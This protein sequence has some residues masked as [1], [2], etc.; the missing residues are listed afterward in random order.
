MPVE[1]IGSE[2]VRILIN[3]IKQKQLKMKPLKKE[4]I[5]LPCSL[6]YRE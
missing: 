3:E 6:N 4:S 1:Q 5:V 2:A